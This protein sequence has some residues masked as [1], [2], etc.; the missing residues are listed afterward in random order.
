MSTARFVLVPGDWLGGWAWDRVF[1]R[2]AVAGH[3]VLAPVA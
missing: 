1:P 2:L 3:P